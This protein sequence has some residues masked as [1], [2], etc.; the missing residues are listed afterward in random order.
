MREIIF[1]TETTGLDK[2]EDRIIEIGAV[3]LANRFPTGRRFHV[4]IDPEGK[5]VHPD[6]ER[7]H[8]ITNAQLAGVLASLARDRVEAP[9]TAIPAYS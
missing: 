4:Y 2:N 3:E 7:V 8:G 9:M 6:A 5:Q 1:D